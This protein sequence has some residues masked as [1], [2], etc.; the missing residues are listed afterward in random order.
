MLLWLLLLRSAWLST[1]ITFEFIKKHILEKGL[2]QHKNF[3]ESTLF[4]NLFQVL[5]TLT[6]AIEVGF[7]SI[8]VISTS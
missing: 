2:K 8:F 1:A 3:R 7:I 6:L 4:L 5:L